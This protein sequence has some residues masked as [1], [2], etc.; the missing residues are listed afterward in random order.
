MTQVAGILTVGAVASI[1]SNRRRDAALARSV[2]GG[3]SEGLTF[4]LMAQGASGAA[5]PLTP[6]APAAASPA[7]V[8]EEALAE[9]GGV[10]RPLGD[11]SLYNPGHSV[12]DASHVAPEGQAPLLDTPAVSMSNDAVGG[13]ST[14]NGDDF[15]PPILEEGEA[16]EGLFGEIPSSGKREEVAHDAASAMEGAAKDGAKSVGD[17]VGEG[18]KGV[19]G[20]AD[21]AANLAGDIDSKIEEEIVPALE[22]GLG[23][24][25]LDKK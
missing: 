21:A 13:G 19:E 22:E 15:L 18:N 5:A 20:V 24:D 10:H 17:T 9:D 7:A 8:S 12:Q 11:D 16:E 3:G 14:G 6:V 25:E 2:S 1:I 23:L 4:N